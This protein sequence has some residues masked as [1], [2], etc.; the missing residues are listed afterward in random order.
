MGFPYAFVWTVARVCR[1]LMTVF[2]VGMIPPTAT[3]G[4]NGPWMFNFRLTVAR[5]MNAILGRYLQARD[6]I[7]GPGSRDQHFASQIVLSVGPYPCYLYFCCGMSKLNS[8]SELAVISIVNGDFSVAYSIGV[9]GA[10]SSVIPPI[11]K[12]SRTFRPVLR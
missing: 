6:V 1:V 8:P 12:G 3:P 11:I 2:W 5:F 7:Q 10:N 4:A 9:I